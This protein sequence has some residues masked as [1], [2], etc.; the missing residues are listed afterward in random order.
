[1]SIIAENGVKDV[2]LKYLE[3]ASPNNSQLEELKIRII[4]SDLFAFSK[5][6]ELPRNIYPA[7][8]VKLIKPLKK[9]TPEKQAKIPAPTAQPA[10]Q[11][12]QDQFNI[13]PKTSGAIQTPFARPQQLIQQTIPK[14]PPSQAYQEPI[15]SQTQIPPP[16]ARPMAPVPPS[17]SEVFQKATTGAKIF[18]PVAHVNQSNIPPPIQAPPIQGP[19]PLRLPPPAS[20]PSTLPPRPPAAKPS[21]QLQNQREEIKQSPQITNPLPIRK[22]GMTSPKPPPV[23]T[24]VVPSATS[25]AAIIKGTPPPMKGR[26]LE[27]AN[28]GIR[29]FKHDVFFIVKCA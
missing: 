1:M 12:K 7:M 22:P 4:N 28:F 3:L 27:Q 9:Q 13:K 10:Q 19:P 2:A 23:P 29:P 8:D 5:I 20:R 15:E 11:I 21:P 17:R 6:Y 14:P 24:V 16:I 25:T 18:Y 26:I